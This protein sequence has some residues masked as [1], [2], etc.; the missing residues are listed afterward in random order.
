MKTIVVDEGSTYTKLAWVDDSGKIKT[1][2]IANA[3]RQGWKTA[4]AGIAPANY[5]IG[6]TKYCYDATA[7]QSIDTANIAYQ[8][9]DQSLLAVHHSLIAT[10]IEP[11]EINLIVTL[12]ITQYYNADDNQSNEHNISRK[13]N[14]L[15]RPITRMHNAPVFTFKTINVMPESLPA[16]LSALSDV[17]FAHERTLCVDCGGTTLDYGVIVGAYEDLSELGGNEKVGVVSVSNRIRAIMSRAGS[18]INQAMSNE[19]I[20]NRDNLD[21]LTSVVNDHNM[22][23]DVMIEIES[24]I[25]SYNNAVIAEIQRFDGKVNRI[26]VCGGGAYLLIDKLKSQFPRISNK[27]SVIENP[28]QALAVEILK[29]ELSREQSKVVA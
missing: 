5:M 3:F 29:I 12:P 21:F 10:G 19:V 11:Q 13:I 2:I 1:S 4:F 24:A 6:D 23:E 15:S 28:Q 25:N 22:L 26:L 14:N 18:E 7:D 16:A 27:I 9:S 17:Q 8:Y 20:T